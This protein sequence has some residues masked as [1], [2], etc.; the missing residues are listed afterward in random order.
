MLIVIFLCGNS[1]PNHWVINRLTDSK[2]RDLNDI[3]RLN[4]KIRLQFNDDRFE[5]IRYSTF[6]M[7]LKLIY[8]RINLKCICFL[9]FHFS[10]Y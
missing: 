3:I 7:N 8:A 5:I 10:S 4:C 9:S 2:Y 6:K 1:Y